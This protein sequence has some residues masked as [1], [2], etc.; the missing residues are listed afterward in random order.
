MCHG[1]TL[2]GPCVQALP[3]IDE[4]AG[5]IPRATCGRAHT[6]AVVRG[7]LASRGSVAISGTADYRG[8]NDE[9]QGFLLISPKVGARS[10]EARTR[11][12]KAE[13]KI[14]ACNHFAS[15]AGVTRW[16]R[17]G[18]P[19]AASAASYRILPAG[20][21][22]PTASAETPYPS[23]MP[24]SRRRPASPTADFSFKPQPSS[25]CYGR[26]ADDY[27]QPYRQEVRAA[28][29]GRDDSRDG[30]APDQDRR[31]RLRADDVRPRVH[32]HRELSQRH[33]L[34]RRRQ[35]RPALSRLPDRTARRRERLSRDG[36]PD[37]VR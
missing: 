16:I 1:R 28:D 3:D 32:E 17:S 19:S 12:E 18:A 25:L 4:K 7:L 37:S 9:L 35:G 13:Y 27:R 8:E 6:S 24:V 21:T 33:H 30:S 34:H 36:V 11:A 5:E 26:H 20:P 10:G 14:R 22:A 2:R 29:P 15:S 23:P 31:R